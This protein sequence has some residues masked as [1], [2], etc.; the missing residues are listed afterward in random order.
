[1][2][3]N[4]CLIKSDLLLFMYLVFFFSKQSFKQVIAGGLSVYEC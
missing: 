1:M 2:E 4:K 3:K